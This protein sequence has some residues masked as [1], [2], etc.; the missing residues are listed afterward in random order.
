MKILEIRAMRGPNYW[1][2]WRHKLIVMTLDLEDYEEK[3]TDKI[4]G[5]LERIEKMFPDMYEHRCSEGVRGGFFQ[6]VSEG[7]WLGHVIEHIALEIQTMAGMDV[8][9]GRTRAAGP[10]GVYH[11]VFAY[12]DEQAGR[13][14]ANAA[15]EIALALAENREY[16]KLQEDLATMKQLHEGGKL[17]PSTEALVEE[18]EM[19]GIPC[20]RL[21]RHSLVQLGYGI[22]QKRM[23]AAVTSKTSNI[24]VEIAGDKENTKNLLQFSGIPVPQGTTIAT[25]EELK[26]AVASYEYPLVIKP[27]NGNHGRGATIDIKNWDAALE[28]FA[29]AKEHSHYVIVEEFIKGHDYRLLVINSKFAAA[30]KRT[31]AMVKGDGKS[32]ISQLIEEVN[33]DPRRGRGHDKVLTKIIVD[34]H[35]LHILKEKELTLESILPEGEIL[36][37]KA[38]A[39]LSTGGTAE[40]VT[41]IVHPYNIFLAER[42]ASI[43]G[44]DICGIDII[45]QDIS[46]AMN[47]NGGAVIEVN[48][49]PGLRMHLAPTEGL[50]RN[51][52]KPIIDMLFPAGSSYRPP[53]VAVTGT[54]GKTT[55][56]RLIAHMAKTAGFKT[57]Y[58]TTEGVYIQDRLVQS[59]D[60]TGPLSAEFVF[61]DPTVEFCVLE[62]A[63]GGILRGGLA[64][65]NCDVGVVTNIAPDHLGLKGINSIEDLARVKSI[66]VETVLPDG[67][68]V[69]NADDDLVYRMRD[70]LDCNIALF[71]MDENNE[72]IQDHI[73]YG[74]LA[75]VYEN[76]YITIMQGKWKNRVMR[77]AD[78]PLTLGGRATF[79]IQNILA[80]VL[81]AHVRKF[82]MRKIRMSLK[83]FLPSPKN[84]PGRMNIFPFK[85]FELMVDYAHNPAGMRAVAEFL[86][87]VEATV[88]VGIVAG[89][90]DR[91]DEDI[92]EVG[93]IA[94]EMFDEIIIRFDRDL[95]ERSADNILALLKE[96][97]ARHPE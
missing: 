32:T 12:E 69:L 28:A 41:D 86:K 61:R 50:G 33:K 27:L 80:A 21:N 10:K 18:A 1:S 90:G 31:P 29:T 37:L 3:P 39:N 55:T 57:G 63:R 17:G 72:R 64:F 82:D 83:N 35:T 54:N 14:A 2:V 4:P 42:A 43:I 65:K 36:H 75:A 44:L 95:R 45:S 7:T 94:A 78:I 70:N 85:N 51:V 60:C 19:R 93:Q 9:F 97:I 30:A 25:V 68:A 8:G 71:S 56:S 48:A 66:I 79:M 34:E 53:I 87:N 62:S 89:V 88:K 77:A 40:D 59:G 23:E 91:R 13:Y 58:T 92:R 74:G 84:T 16:T 24:A 22:C 11:V 5:F 38:T 73:Y 76:G 46:V 96:G 52:A 26:E 67:Y 20:I 6:R 47:R 15:M 49:G 81:A